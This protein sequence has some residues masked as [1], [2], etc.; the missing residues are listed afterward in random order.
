VVS[1]AARRVPDASALPTCD[2]VDAV[3]ARSL[4]SQSSKE[5]P[6]S[7]GTPVDQPM[8]RVLFVLD[9]TSR[10]QDNDGGGGRDEDSAPG[11]AGG[12]P[13]P[14]PAPDSRALCG[15]AP[16]NTE[17]C[18][19]LASRAGEM[20]ASDASDAAYAC[21]RAG[22]DLKAE[23]GRVLLDAVCSRGPGP[24]SAIHKLYIDASSRSKLAPTPK[25]RPG[26]KPRRDPFKVPRGFAVTDV[27][28][29]A[30][31]LVSLPPAAERGPAAQ[32]RVLTA[33]SLAHLAT[34]F[35]TDDWSRQGGSVVATYKY[36][37]STHRT[38]LQSCFYQKPLC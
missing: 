33:K 26:D 9:D 22:C 6:A 16:T 1:A 24:L 10:S 20:T 36:W 12:A 18:A 7:A 2:L 28:H 25:R 21:A 4:H 37:H 3:I 31:A 38:K 14:T 13:S 19:A 11:W 30:F 29:L 5:S 8:Q 23:P 27:V 32:D 15:G 34:L 35:N 17:V